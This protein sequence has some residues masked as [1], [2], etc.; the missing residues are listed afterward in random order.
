[1]FGSL[2]IQSRAS[3]TN[4]SVVVEAYKSNKENLFQ[5]TQPAKK[6]HKTL[7]GLLQECPLLGQTQHGLG[8]L[9]A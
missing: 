3:Y 4:S 6:Q 9:I 1:M 7:Q 8:N 5:A 2:T